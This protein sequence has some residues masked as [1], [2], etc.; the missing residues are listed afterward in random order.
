M[1][2]TLPKRITGAINGSDSS[3]GDP[4]N[5]SDESLDDWFVIAAPT[6]LA[7]KPGFILDL[8]T[9]CGERNGDRYANGSVKVPSGV[10]RRLL[11]LTNGRAWLNA[12]MWG[13]KAQW[14][15]DLQRAERIAAQ[16]DK[17]DLR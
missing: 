4:T 9:G 13:C 12:I 11:H 3:V 15:L 8:E 6:L 5:L 14:W 10:V 1:H 16:V 17:L 2:G 7:P